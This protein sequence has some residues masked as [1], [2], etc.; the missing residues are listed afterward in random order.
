IKAGLKRKRSGSDCSDSSSSID[1][2]NIK[3][4]ISKLEKKVK[5]QE[6]DEESVPKKGKKKLTKKVKKEASDEESVPKKGKKKEKKLTPEEAAQE[7]YLSNQ[8]LSKLEGVPVG[9][10]SL[11]DLDEREANH[12]FVRL[13]VGQFYL[14]ELK[15]IRVNDIASKLVAAQEIDFLFKVNFLTLFTNMM[16]KDAGLKGQICLDV[17]RRLREDCVIS[18]ID[19]YGYIYDCLQGSKC[20]ILDIITQARDDGIKGNVTSSKPATLPDAINMARELVEQ[21]AQGRATRIGESNKRKWEDH[22]RNNNN[23][24]NNNNNRNRNN[25]YYQQQNRRQETARAYAAAPTENKGYAGNLPRCNCCNSH[26]NGQCPPKCQKYQRTGHREKDCRVRVPGAGVNRLQDMTCYEC[27]EKGHSKDKC[28]K[29]MNQPNEGAHGRA[30]VKSFV[31]FAFKP[32][33]D[34]APT[35]LNTSYEVELADGKDASNFEILTVL[36][37]AYHAILTVLDIVYHAIL[38]VLDIVHHA[39]LTVLDIVYHAIVTVLD[40]VYHATLTVLN[41]VYH[42]ILTVLDIVYHAIHTLNN[43]GPTLI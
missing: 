15:Q 17:V 16:G 19:W 6:S 20:S 2:E 1:T 37:I 7:E 36:D 30:Y 25:N 31:S 34:I 11:F 9:G 10:Y 35:A 26:H 13:W 14:T 3:L 32:F 5:K 27:G 12:E 29:G 21:A 33:I 38:T 42:A 28:P 4:L 41:I 24:N 40:I 8:L 18:D 22:Q 43:C 23:N 39:I